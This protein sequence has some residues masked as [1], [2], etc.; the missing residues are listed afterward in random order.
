MS[1]NPTESP[2][3]L[4]RVVRWWAAL[5]DADTATA[6]GHR[7]AC[8]AC[9]AYFES[10][11]TLE[12]RLRHDARVHP[13]A[14]PVGLEQRIAAAVHRAHSPARVRRRQP[15]VWWAAGLTTAAAAAALVLVMHRSPR[16]HSA[17]AEAEP[18]EIAAVF[19]AV[20]EFPTQLEQLLPRPG[21]RTGMAD[22]L[23]HEFDNVKADARSALAF[24]A[25]NFLPP[26]REPTSS[27]QE[28][29]PSI[30]DS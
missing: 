13:S 17:T 23:D 14:A 1:T 12:T 18:A 7:A 25:A 20:T 26:H 28:R 22:P 19:K 5:T 11:A 10:H 27:P 16:P 21:T 2:R 4:C 29:A 8:P 3:L 24:L 9:R 30:R 6:T 15:R